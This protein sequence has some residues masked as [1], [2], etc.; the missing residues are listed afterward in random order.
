MN[1][2]ERRDATRKARRIHTILDLLGRGYNNGEID[3]SL[4]DPYTKGKNAE[5][6]VCDLLITLPGIKRVALTKKGGVED[7]RGVD[8]FVDIIETGSF[9][10]VAV[11]V[12]ANPRLTNAFYKEMSKKYFIPFEEV[13]Q[14]LIKKGVILLDA[15][16]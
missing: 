7:R 12:K 16:L 15:S 14:M 10:R 2:S 4:N 11:Q 1:R 13:A 5:Q 9:E 3:R 6:L 8:M